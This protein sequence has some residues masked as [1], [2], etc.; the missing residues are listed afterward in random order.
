MSNKLKLTNVRLSFNA[1]FNPESK[2]DGEPKFSALF[3][4]DKESDSGKENWK[5]I[6]EAIRS[7]EQS[8]LGGTELPI[9]KLPIQ[10]GNNEDG[11]GRYL[12]WKDCFIVTTGNRKRPVVVGRKRQPV[13]EGDVDAPY[14]GCYCNVIVSPWA[15]NHA[16]YGK[17]II[18]SL[19]A[20]QMAADG[21]PFV[22]ST[23]D[24]STDF[25]DIEGDVTEVASSV[26]DL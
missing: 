16:T 18:F 22:S 10:N 8:D 26:F 7:L 2:F 9:D 1:I 4:I 5:K 17:R 14:S 19:E 13:A 25:D 21:E 12:G 6:K 11:E 15:M 20:I 24:V 23:V 3:I